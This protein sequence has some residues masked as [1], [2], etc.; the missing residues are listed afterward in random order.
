M[1]SCKDWFFNASLR[2]MNITT[3]ASVNDAKAV[4]VDINPRALAAGIGTDF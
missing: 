3:T 1:C 2:H 4:N